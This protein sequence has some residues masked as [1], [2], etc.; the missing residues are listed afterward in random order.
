[1]AKRATTLNKAEMTESLYAEFGLNKRESKEIVDQFFAEIRGC[2][3]RDEVVKLSGYGNFELRHKNARPGRNPR[4]G[5]TIPIRA[6]RVVIFR[7]GLK[8]K[9]RVEAH[10]GQKN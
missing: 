6:R 5:E 2:L 4:T 7:P 1:M 8:L 3:Q 10:G 9:A